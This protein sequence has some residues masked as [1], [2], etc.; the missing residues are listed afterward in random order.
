MR[1]ARYG[2]ASRRT[3]AEDRGHVVP[4]WFRGLPLSGWFIPSAVLGE[5]YDWP[6][7][8]RR[9]ARESSGPSRAPLAPDA[10]DLPGQGVNGDLVK[11]VEKRSH[12]CPFTP[13]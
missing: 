10:S 7:C 13:I 1:S 6:G 9:G 8:Y 3:E 4:F 5:V 12:V 2:D 11:E